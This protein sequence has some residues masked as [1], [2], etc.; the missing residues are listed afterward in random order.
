VII[1]AICTHNS[2]LE[3]QNLDPRA[4]IWGGV[5]TTVYFLRDSLNFITILWTN[6]ENILDKMEGVGLKKVK[7][8]F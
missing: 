2:S 6:A 1:S 8:L 3:N 7:D 5:E 4:Y